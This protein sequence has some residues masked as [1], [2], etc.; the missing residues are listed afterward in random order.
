MLPQKQQQCSFPQTSRITL[1]LY[2]WAIICPQDNTM[3][4]HHF[5]WGQNI[6]FL[7]FI[8]CLYHITSK[9][10]QQSEFL[11]TLWSHKGILILTMHFGDGT[12]H[13]QHPCCIFNIAVVFSTP[14]HHLKQC[15]P[16]IKGSQEQIYMNWHFS[17]ICPCF[18]NMPLILIGLDIKWKYQYIIPTKIST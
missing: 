5:N 8:Y 2:G 17:E 3:L 14:C 7:L 13:T 9:L 1:S 15:L 12:I 18:R 4:C 16:V 10:K 6:K 11:L